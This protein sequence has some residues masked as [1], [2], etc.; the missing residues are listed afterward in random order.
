MKINFCMILWL[1]FQSVSTIQGTERGISKID[2]PQRKLQTSSKFHN[3]Y[4]VRFPI[5]I[6]IMA[7]QMFIKK[8]TRAFLNIRL[9][10]LI[11]QKY[12]LWDTIMLRNKFRL[13]F[14]VYHFIAIRFNS[15][16]LVWIDGRMILLLNPYIYLPFTQSPILYLYLQ[17]HRLPILCRFFMT[18]SEHLNL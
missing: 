15:I 16:N 1:P 14:F 7:K 12:N 2:W 8:K 17:Y 10:I 9:F 13:S 11:W 4:M 6:A 5:W 18:L 3:N